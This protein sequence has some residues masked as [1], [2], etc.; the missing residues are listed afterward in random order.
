MPT[1]GETAWSLTARDIVTA[2][3]QENAITA[4]G[5]DPKA[6]EMDACLVRLNGLLKSWRVG[7]HLEQGATVTV[8]ADSA[9]GL[10]DE[11][12]GEV[13][14]VRLVISATNERLLARWERDQ[15]FS[16]PN[17]TSSGQPVA[18]YTADSLAG[19]TIY[20]YP[21]PSVETTL[22]VDYLRL[23]ETITDTGQTVDFPERY[24][25][26]LYSNLAV[27]CA[28]LFGVQP[29]QELFQRA[30]RLRREVEDAERPASYLLEPEGYCA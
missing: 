4:L 27:R 20:L 7:M 10:L 14:S 11:G 8:P 5:R 6:R 3:L 28:G 25:E 29:S 12:I 17:K 26:A 9:S 24:T 1:S 23:P 21:V 15:Y 16:I 18:Y 22:K 2:A 19:S 13:L 30:E